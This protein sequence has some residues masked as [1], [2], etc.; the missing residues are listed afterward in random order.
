MGPLG[1]RHAAS[2]ADGWMPVDVALPDVARAVADFR[3]LLRDNDRNPDNVEITLVVMSAV[4]ADLLKSY[5]DVGI[6]RCNIGV[7]QNWDKPE[8]VMPMIEQFSKLIPRSVGRQLPAA[9]RAVPATA[10]GS[11]QVQHPL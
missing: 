4:T 3:Q 6:D 10:C 9:A 11:R 1:V 8:V 7:A 2:W 5:R